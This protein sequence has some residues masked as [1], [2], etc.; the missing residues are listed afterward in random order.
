MKTLRWGIMQ[1]LGFSVIAVGSAFTP[2][3]VTAQGTS[4]VVRGR[5][6]AQGQPLPA[7][8]QVIATNSASGFTKQA[9]TQ[10][11][12]AY[13]LIGL[14]PGTYQL[15]IQGEGYQETAR[16]VRVQIGQTIDLDLEA[17]TEAVAV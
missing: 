3:I 8:V 15:R 14:A 1:A 7:G 12:G 10:E 13:A 17:A 11:G 9:T 6:L 4:A 16:A 2:S 5:V